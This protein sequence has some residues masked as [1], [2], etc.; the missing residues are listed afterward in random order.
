MA[1]LGIKIRVFVP[2][3]VLDF[4]TVRNQIESTMIHKTGPEIRK[5]FHRT[6]QTWNEQP[7]WK[8]E[9]YRGVGVMWVKVFTYSTVYRLV[10]SGA[11]PHPIYPRRKKLLRFQRGFKAKTRPRLIGSFAG[12]K[13]GP[14]F[15]S[16]GVKHPGHEAREFDKTIA[17]EYQDT[18]ARDI[19]DAVSK[20]IVHA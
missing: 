8:T 16:R 7:N 20:G 2:K 18:F 11:G 14:Y 6:V 12:G 3:A 4:G 10:N 1:T 17:E 9:M 19:Q 13:S 15:S 5:E